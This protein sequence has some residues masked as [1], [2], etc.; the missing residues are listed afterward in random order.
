VVFQEKHRSEQ[1]LLGVAE[2]GS[3][4][5]DN[6]TSLQT[7]LTFSSQPFLATFLRRNFLEVSF[8]VSFAF[9]PHFYFYCFSR[10]SRLQHPFLENFIRPAFSQ[11]RIHPFFF[12]D[13]DIHLQLYSR[14]PCFFLFLSRFA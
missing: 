11:Q 7:Q 5:P 12:I 9:F 14:E 4:Q 1:N 2:P 8:S 10:F 6:L 13:I 3:K